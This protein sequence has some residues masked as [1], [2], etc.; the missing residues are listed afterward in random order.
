MPI[1]ETGLAFT[2]PP[3][4]DGNDL[5]E[6]Q[7]MRRR[8]SGIPGH[9]RNDHI[10]RFLTCCTTI[11]GLTPLQAQQ[12]LEFAIHE[13]TDFLRSEEFTASDIKSLKGRN[14]REPEMAFVLDQYAPFIE[15]LFE[16]RSV[17][18]PH[19]PHNVQFS[20]V[21]FRITWDVPLS[22]REQ[23]LLQEIE[24]LKQKCKNLQITN[25]S[26]PTRRALRIAQD[27]F[28]TLRNNR[29]M[30]VGGEVRVPCVA[31]FGRPQPPLL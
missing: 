2:F 5:D 14:W 11:H 26:H 1:P 24:M 20:P 12:R 6:R 7:R 28:Q 19:R 9:S 29:E 3:P 15:R 22:R 21:D 8:Y 16:V 30:A 23:E 31:C 4:D 17:G 10:S 13:L 27:N 25:E 18:Y